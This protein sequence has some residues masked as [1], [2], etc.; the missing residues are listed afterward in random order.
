MCFKSVGIFSFIRQTYRPQCIFWLM[1]LQHLELV[2]QDEDDEFECSSGSKRH[3]VQ[4][5]LPAPALLL[6]RVAHD[7]LPPPEPR[8]EVKRHVG[9]RLHAAAT[10]EVYLEPARQRRGHRGEASTWLH[11]VGVMLETGGSPVSIRRH[12][13]LDDD[14]LPWQQTAQDGPSEGD[15]LW[16]KP[17]W[18]LDQVNQDKQQFLNQCL[19]IICRLTHHENYR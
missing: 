4:D 19:Q 12:W 17:S 2:S 13:S 15:R 6:Q 3:P 5:L 1:A 8:V 9:P 7:A 16:G 18:V 11:Q 10:H 14:H